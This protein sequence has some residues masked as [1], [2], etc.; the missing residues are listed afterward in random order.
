MPSRP[1][2]HASKKGVL[3]SVRVEPGA[4]STTIVGR[5]GDAVKVRVGAPPTDGRANE[6]VLALIAKEFGLSVGDVAITS[7][8]T[9]RTK[10]VSLGDLDLA[11]A[12]RHLDRI[13]GEDARR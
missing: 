3:L 7:G 6:A 1:E 5:H 8:H 12:A 2:L 9:S 13:L 4:G 10:R 11:T